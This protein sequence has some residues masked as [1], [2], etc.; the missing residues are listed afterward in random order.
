MLTVWDLGVFGVMM[1]LLMTPNL[2]YAA[3]ATGFDLSIFR[4]HLAFYLN[5]SIQNLTLG[6]WPLT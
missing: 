6:M 5:V 2:P 3:S 1:A 4:T